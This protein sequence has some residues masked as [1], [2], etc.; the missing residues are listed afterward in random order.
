[1]R[2]LRPLLGEALHTAAIDW[3]YLVTVPTIACPP[4]LTRQ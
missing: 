3:H 2:N 1:V 4:A